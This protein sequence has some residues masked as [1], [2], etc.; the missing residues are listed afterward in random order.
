MGEA[1]RRLRAGQI[2]SLRRYDV[3]QIPV[4]ASSGGRFLPRAASMR[5]SCQV[6]C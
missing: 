5:C 1:K 2:T 3:D 6:F 4:E